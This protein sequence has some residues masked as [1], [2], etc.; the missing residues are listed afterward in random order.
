MRPE[1]QRL[2]HGLLD[3]SSHREGTLLAGARIL[4]RRRIWRRVRSGLVLAMVVAAAAVST[5]HTRSRPT[6]SISKAATPAYG[7]SL[8]DDELL[9]L[10]PDTPVGLATLSDGHKRLI[11]PRPDDEKRFVSRL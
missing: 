4:R 3:G 10:F 7:K 11:F 1:K 6:A 9:A 2:I 8:T 5:Q